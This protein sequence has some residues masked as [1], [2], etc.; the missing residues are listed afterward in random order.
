MS[1]KVWFTSDLH[2]GHKG[3]LNFCPETRPFSD[4]D[5]MEQAIIANWQQQ[6]AQ[7][8]RVYILGDVFFCGPDKAHKIIDQLPGQKHLIFGN[9]DKTIRNNKPLRDKFVSTSE[10]KE[11]TLDKV[12]ICMFHFPIWEWYQIHR[13]SYHLFGHVHGNN[14]VPGRAMDVGIDSRTDCKLWSWEEVNE[15]LRWREIRTHHNKR[16][17]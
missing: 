14:A 2:F 7:N 16:A 12:K 4:I 11:I 5:E 8:D 9:H 6:V 13:G 10:Y 3:I 17:D 15:N 1:E